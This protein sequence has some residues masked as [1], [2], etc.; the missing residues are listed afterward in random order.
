MAQ[1]I[2]GAFCRLSDATRHFSR[3]LQSL[4]DSVWL[5]WADAGLFPPYCR[6]GDEV[7]F[8]RDEIAGW[9]RQN[10]SGPFVAALA[11][12]GFKEQR[13]PTGAKWKNRRQKAAMAKA[14]GTKK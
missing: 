1:E 6:S 7:L 8:R 4:P 5:G 13:D 11:A 2:N 12:A 10:L 3:Y 14:E 9:A